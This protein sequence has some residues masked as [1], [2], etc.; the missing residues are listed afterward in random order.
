MASLTSKL[1]RNKRRRVTQ[2][3]RRERELEALA[4]AK[5]AEPNGEN[6]VLCLL[7]FERRGLDTADVHTFGPQQNV[8]RFNAWRAL[9]RTVKRGEHGVR[10]TVWG[11][12]GK[13]EIDPTTGEKKPRKCGPVTAYVFHVSQTAE[14]G[15]RG[16]AQVA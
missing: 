16:K 4:S 9:G 7:E 5:R 14:L 8:F 6:D 12:I 1:P 10:L 11:P 15:E 13:V 2:A 3:E